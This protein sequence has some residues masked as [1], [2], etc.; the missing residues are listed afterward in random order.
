MCV[1]FRPQAGVLLAVGVYVD[2]LLVTRT[3]QFAVD[4]VFCELVSLPI[5]NLGRP[6]QFLG[7]RIVYD[8]SDGHR[9]AKGA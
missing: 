9:L 2:A 4:A 1:Y 3:E 5:K 7:I 6:H 8:D